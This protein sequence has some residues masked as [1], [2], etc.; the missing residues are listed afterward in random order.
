MLTPFQ[1][2]EL[3]NLISRYFMLAFSLSL[4]KVFVLESSSNSFQR[5]MRLLLLYITL[6]KYLGS[7]RNR[8]HVFFLP[9]SMGAKLSKG[10]P[11]CPLP[12]AASVYVH[13]NQ[14]SVFVICNS[15]SFFFFV[16]YICQLQFFFTFGFLLLFFFVR[17]FFGRGARPFVAA[18]WHFLASVQWLPVWQRPSIRYINAASIVR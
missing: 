4:P 14:I 5:W 3:I 2:I 17:F 12:H 9:S 1:L 13:K 7:V 8:M 16:Y 18:A 15:F 6:N 11:L 10:S